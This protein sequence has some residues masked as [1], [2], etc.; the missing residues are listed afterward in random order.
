MNCLLNKD[1]FHKVIGEIYKIT[2]VVNNK[3]YVGQTRS[4]RLNRNKY[5]PFGYIGRFNDHISEARVQKK[6]GCRYLNNA[7]LKYG[8]ENFKCDLIVTC[9]IAELDNYEIKYIAE[10]NA[11][12][13]DGYNLT[14]GGQTKGSLKGTKIV[15][16]N[17][18]PV[19]AEPRLPNPNLKRSEYT[20]SLISKRL[21]E[22]KRDITHRKEKMVVVQK[23]H[24]SNK[25]DQFKEVVFDANNIDKYIHV[26]RNNLQNYEYVKIINGKTKTSFVG[27]YET[28][29]EIKNRA[30]MFMLE[31]IKWQ[32]N[33]IAG[34]PLEPSLPL[35]YGNTCEE[36]G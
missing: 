3:C 1:E 19:T 20:K 6:A 30:R 26:V 10:L 34:T 27:K 13:P 12:Y 22:F 29:D 16:D 7:L 23:Q 17:L 9:E 31:L 15:L 32:R 28:I 18:E 21:I 35:T 4:H 11:K 2:N 14:D 8:V 33:Q 5:R 36:L 24:L 25:F